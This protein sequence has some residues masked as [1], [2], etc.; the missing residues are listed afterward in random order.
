MKLGK[1]FEELNISKWSA[2]WAFLSDGW[3]GLAELIC[4]AFTK[5]LRKADPEKLKKYAQLAAK[6]AVFLRGMVETFIE[7]GKVR[8]AA[9][10]AADAVQVLAEHLADGEYTTAELDI[11]VDNIRDCIVAWQAV[12]KECA[13]CTDKE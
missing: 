13:D 3:A 7:E 12:D 11:D 2:I 1:F 6:I 4:T 5:L 9:L 10:K 8:V